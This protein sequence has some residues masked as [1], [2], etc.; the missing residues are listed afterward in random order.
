MKNFKIAILGNS[1]A[2]RVRPPLK[3]PDN[4]NYG[5]IMEMLLLN[6]LPDLNVM[7]EN[8]AKGA[9]TIVNLIQDIDNQLNSFPDFFILN[10]GVVDSCT[11]EV[12][13][14]FYDLQDKKTD[15]L[16]RII[17]AS[18]YSRIFQKNR[19]FFVRIRGKRSWISYR[20]YK[21]YFTRALTILT[22]ETNAKIIVLAINLANNRV[23]KEPPGSKNN[24]IKFNRLMEEVAINNGHFFID[25]SD[26]ISNLHY[27]DGVHFSKQGHEIIAERI[28]NI[29]LSNSSFGNN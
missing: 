19:P 21:K 26:L 28:V 29:I 22:K 16:L 12:P 5:K 4:I 18:V 20:K 6:K 25:T 9:S 17:A 2:L 10:F 1:V 8:K 3:A 24:Q 14:W 13:K 27:P 23:E 11:R 7:V 15:N